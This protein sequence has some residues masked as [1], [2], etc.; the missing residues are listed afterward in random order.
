[1][2]KRNTS[3]QPSFFRAD[4]QGQLLCT[5]AGRITQQLI[6]TGEVLLDVPGLQMQ[7]VLTDHLRAF[8]TSLF[9]AFPEPRKFLLQ[10]IYV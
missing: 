9:P 3:L 4:K 7:G 10:S 8:L 5:A 1:M 2:S 6:P